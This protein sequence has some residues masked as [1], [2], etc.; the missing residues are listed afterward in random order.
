MDI[1][2]LMIDP[3]TAE[4]WLGTNTLNRPVRMS[5]VT[6]YARDMSSGRWKANG[7][8]VKFDKQGRLRDGQHRLQAIVLSGV[9]VPLTVAFGLEEDAVGTVDAGIS[10][11]AADLLNMKG[12]P[13]SALQGAVARL[14]LLLG[15]TGGVGN[16]KVTHTEVDEHVATHPELLESVHRTEEARKLV[17]G[18]RPSLIVYADLTLAK[19][20]DSAAEKFWY[21]AA[22]LT[23]TYNGDA[24]VAM[25]R[26]FADIYVKR[27]QLSD[28]EALS[29]VYRSWNR[30][31][32]QEV[33]RSVKILPARTLDDLPRVR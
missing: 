7:E 6:A 20:D 22:T 25:S 17:R 32:R 23:P 8:T 9:T 16:K 13:H 28:L 31:R 11:T 27:L 3:D 10:R 33:T 18:C 15:G 19:V 24:A 21:A 5:V 1:R 30:W 4:V 2:T 26:R 12:V 14:A 29:V